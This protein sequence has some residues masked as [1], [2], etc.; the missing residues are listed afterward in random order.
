MEMGANSILALFDT[1]AGQRESFAHA[2][3][4]G[5]ADGNVNPLDVHLQIRA[6][7]DI[8]ERIT[9]SK[10][11]KSA[12]LD[13][14]QRYGKS[15]EYKNA[16][17]SIRETGVRYDFS[18]CNSSDYKSFSEKFEEAKGWMKEHEAFL[19]TLP[20]EG[21]EVVSEDGEVHRVFPPAKSS[22]TSVTVKLK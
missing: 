10:E 11:Y 9:S 7:E 12:L 15:F 8:I 20:V 3:V 22:T 17:L 6:M 19:E 21:V 5:V 2:I 13:E 18:K 1:N 4:R 16:E 14:A